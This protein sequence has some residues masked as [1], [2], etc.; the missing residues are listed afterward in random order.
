MLSCTHHNDLQYNIVVMKASR[1]WKP[2]L[3]GHQ[4]ASLSRREGEIKEM[5][6]PIH[7]IIDRNGGAQI[8][9]FEKSRHNFTHHSA[10]F[11]LWKILWWGIASGWPHSLLSSLQTLLIPFPLRLNFCPLSVVSSNS[12]HVT[13]VTQVLA[14]DFLINKLQSFIFLLCSIFGCYFRKAMGFLSSIVSIKLF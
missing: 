7:W 6:E 4:Y 10:N 1:V 12:S 5:E 13:H 14:L 2:R 3:K 8:S 11:L 9:L